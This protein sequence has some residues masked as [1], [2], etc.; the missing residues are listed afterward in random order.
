MFRKSAIILTFIL[1]A[2]AA[3]QQAGKPQIKKA[4]ARYT[5]P[6]SGKE[7]Y[8]EYCASCHGKDGKGAGPA[9]PA[10]KTAPTDL[11]TLA[12]SNGGTF[13]TSRFA[14]VLSGKTE[15]VAHGSQ[16]MPVWGKVFFRMS[17]QHEGEVQ[18]RISNLAN[19]V[20]SMQQK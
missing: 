10:L 8:D 11:T 13:P 2:A 17:G 16:E 19:Y 15:I 1:V 5:S 3:A 20:Q 7:M 12:K 9:A 18:L 6:A 4:P 14:S